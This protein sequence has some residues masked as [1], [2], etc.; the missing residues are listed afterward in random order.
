MLYKKPGGFAETTTSQAKND[1]DN[2]DD[3]DDDN[4]N[5]NSN[6]YSKTACEIAWTHAQ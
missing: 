2:D 3:D 1:N 4:Y 5:N 6:N